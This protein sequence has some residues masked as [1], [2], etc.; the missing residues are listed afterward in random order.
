MRLRTPGALVGLVLVLL[1]SPARAE[2][3]TPVEVSVQAPRSPPPATLT[4]TLETKTIERLGSTTV[5][6]TLERLPSVTSGADSRGERTL[7]LRGFAQRQIAVYVDGIPLA[8]PYDGQ[9]D[10]SKLPV[11]LVARLTVVQAASTSLVGP[12]ALGGAIGI[13]LR[14][15]AAR[16][17][18]TAST[19]SSLFRATRAGLSATGRSG[20]W[21]A[22]AGGSLQGVR[23]TPLSADFTRAPNE[24]GGDRN[25]SDRRATTG[26]G[27]V[28]VDLGDAHRLSLLVSRFGGQYGV[29]PITRGFQTRFWRWTEWSASTL[30]LSHAYRGGR[31]TTDETVY[32]SAFENL[33]DAYDGPSYTTQRLGK[34]FHSLYDD[35]SVGTTLRAGAPFT[36]P[37]GDARVEA[38][39][40]ARHDRHASQGDRDEPMV[41]VATSL[42]TAATRVEGELI[43]ALLSASAAV[44]LDAEIPS[45]APSGPTPSRAWAPGPAFGLALR[46][47]SSLS[48]MASASVRTRF[49]TLRERF[50]TVFGAREPNTGLSPEQSRNVSLDAELRPSKRLSL[51]AGLFASDVRDEIATVLLRP[52][53]DRLVNVGR[54]RIAGAEARVNAAPNRYLEAA[55]GAVVMDLDRLEGATP[56]VYRPN[57]RGLAMLTLLPLPWLSFSGVVRYVGAQAYQ[58]PD[59]GV[60]GKL[61]AYALLDARAD[62]TLRPGVRTYV[63]VQNLLD[64]NVESRWSFPEAGRQGFV[65]LHATLE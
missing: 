61:E 43:R 46:P 24:D 27:K 22:I 65:G 4:D 52:G 37:L 17:S 36:T 23:S 51:A 18:L 26:M 11:D 33:L 64:A 5:G 41:L 32:V 25:N 10:L 9:L 57:R 47:T 8:V 48:I 3:G 50:S 60:D 38:W 6:E 55:L 44:Q 16:A 62:L 53:I 12:N 34:A 2:E 59:T 58:H 63:R 7:T 49:P 15:P 35:V 39:A 56:V 45:A 42:V 1:A 54:L 28:S 21:G 14:E 19:E 13:V 20:P 31:F 40:G 30:G 29:P